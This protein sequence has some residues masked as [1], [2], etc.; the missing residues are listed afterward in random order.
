V[1]D[2]DSGELV[3]ELPCCGDADDILI[4]RERGRAYVIGGEGAVTVVG[5]ADPGRY[6]VVDT[7]ATRRGA[8][9]GWLDAAGG[10]LYVAC[11]AGDGHEAELM[12]LTQPT[13]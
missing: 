9:T 5:I 13:R 10:R 11:P 4:D 7:V 3:A 6:T 1:L 2:S 12:V 8:R